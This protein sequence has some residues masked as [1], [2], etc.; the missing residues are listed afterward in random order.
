MSNF[1][2]NYYSSLGVKAVDVKPSIE[3]AL[4][5]ETLQNDRL[6]KLCL[7]VRI[8]HMYR[9]LVWKVLLQVLPL[10]K[11]LWDATGQ[12]KNEQYEWMF[13]VG[14]KLFRKQELD[15]EL[16]VRLVLIRLDMLTPAALFAY[17]IP[18]HLL[19]MAH[20]FLEICDLDERD[21]LWIMFAY[22][23]RLNVPLLIKHDAD[24]KSVQDDIS[25]MVGLLSKHSVELF[26]HLDRL[27]ID[28]AVLNPWF[29]SHF[30][31]VLD[32]HSLEGIWDIVIGGAPT[33]FPY[34]GLCL[35]LNCK[36]RILELRSKEEFEKLVKQ[37][38]RYVDV[39]TV[40]QQSVEKWERP[41]LDK[42]SA[43][44]RTLLGYNS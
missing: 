40:A 38:T 44:T 5:G 28:Y 36:K 39:H 25:T 32:I 26:E 19:D 35:L 43:E 2:Q 23:Q 15:P 21:A 37:I 7:W 8:P 13:L 29:L 30:S 42:M 4:S 6:K 24:L 18:Q 10:E 34:I 22:V 16:I 1:R 9:A 3:N 14:T 31:N 41:I 20:A 12:S 27:Q 17:Q 33:I 11:Q